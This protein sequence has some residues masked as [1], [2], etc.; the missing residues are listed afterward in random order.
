[1]PLQWKS[2]DSY[3]LGQ[4]PIP[5]WFLGYNY[6]PPHSTNI[7]FAETNKVGTKERKKDPYHKQT[8]NYSVLLGLSLEFVQKHHVDND[9][10]L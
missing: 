1:M 5:F 6:N 8:T 3:L 9:V 7:I 4:G 2:R 10:R